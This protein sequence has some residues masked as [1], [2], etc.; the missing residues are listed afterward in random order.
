MLLAIATL[1]VGCRSIPTN[2]SQESSIIKLDPDKNLFIFIG[3]KI[4]V[5]KFDPNAQGQNETRTKELDE[6]TGDSVTVV[7]KKYVMDGAFHCKYKVVKSLFNILPQDTIDFDAYD[8]YGTPQ[9]SNSDTIIMYI[10]KSENGQYFFHQK[11]QYDVVFKDEKGNY[12]SYPKF[13]G[14]A[15]I[16]YGEKHL[17][18][19][20]YNFPQVKFNISKLSWEAVKIHFPKK[21]YRIEKQFATPKKGIYL[22]VLIN[23]RLNTTFKDLKQ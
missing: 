9:F 21:F 3:E 15:D 2:N 12:Y 8:H 11:Y 22:D 13:N 19:F 5:D 4:S 23:Y 16:L 10:S 6:E 7:H 14:T 20:D 17:K 18:G 1:M